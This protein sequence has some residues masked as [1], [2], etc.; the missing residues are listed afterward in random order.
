LQ[1]HDLTP[2]PNFAPGEVR[3]V[4][5]RWV[6]L[7]DGRLMLRY[8]VDGCGGLVLPPFRGR[9]RADDLWKTTCFELFL[10]DGD[11]RYREFNFSPSGQWA[12]YDFSGYRNRV[13]SYEPRRTPEINHESGR[14]LFVQTVFVD[15][16]ELDGAE[17]AAL[18]AVIEEQG[19]RPSY[20]SLAHG[21]LKP[22]FHD[23]ACFRIPL[24]ATPGG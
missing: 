13:G 19:G 17:R 16:R 9:G 12:A 6:E 1:T 4:S 15:R 18:A 3:G 14:S 7:P 11:G 21:A 20:W 22:D 5:V 10:Y 24:P 23:P 2:H 8:R